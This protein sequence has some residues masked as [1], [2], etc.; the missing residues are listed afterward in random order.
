[1]KTFPLFMMVQIAMLVPS[2]PTTSDNAHPV[3]LKVTLQI[4]TPTQS[5]PMTTGK[6]ARAT[7]GDK[8]TSRRVQETSET[9]RRF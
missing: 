7:V 5:D 8:E 2:D 4:W 3:F 9:R 1:M 6:T